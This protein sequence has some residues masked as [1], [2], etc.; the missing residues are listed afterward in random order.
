MPRW[1]TIFGCFNPRN[2]MTARGGKVPASTK[3][4]LTDSDHLDEPVPPLPGDREMLST[5]TLRARSKALKLT[6]TKQHWHGD[7][8]YELIGENERR[9]PIN[10]VG[11][12]SAWAL[13]N[14][15]PVYAHC[16][17]GGG[18]WTALQEVVRK[19]ACASFDQV[20]EIRVTRP[21]QRGAKHPAHADLEEAE[22][23]VAALQKLFPNAKITRWFVEEG[24][25]TYFNQAGEP[26][27]W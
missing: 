27:P 20:T 9:G 22:A 17:D 8:G 6:Q 24:V 18:E 2:K 11:C 1:R 3:S 14:G 26:S 10:I 15:R 23:D 16:S 13:V 19:R 7:N 12:A 5:K 4:D 25:T 21:T